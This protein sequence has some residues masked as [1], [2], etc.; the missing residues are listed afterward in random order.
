MTKR[1]GR[2]R[3]AGAGAIVAFGLAAA[4]A[5][6]AV[7]DDIQKAYVDCLGEQAIE[8]CSGALTKE[9]EPGETRKPPS[10]D[11]VVAA[12]SAER[13]AFVERVTSRNLAAGRTADYAARRVARH[14]GRLEALV[15][16]IYDK[17]MD[18]TP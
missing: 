12:C 11:E 2:I 1:L 7:D 18:T 17:C 15:R 3:G 13:S 16:G 14:T 8:F 10:F 4:P 9:P 6:A 5:L